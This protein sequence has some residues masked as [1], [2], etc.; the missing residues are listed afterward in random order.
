MTKCSPKKKNLHFYCNRKQ[1][2]IFNETFYSLSTQ[3]S[4]KSLITRSWFEARWTL[5]AFEVKLH[6]VKSPVWWNS[7][8]R[9]L[10][11]FNKMLLF[12]FLASGLKKLLCPGF[13][14]SVPACFLSLKCNLYKTDADWTYSERLGQF[15]KPAEKPRD[16][17]FICSPKPQSFQAC[18]HC[19]VL[20]WW[21]VS[22]SLK[23]F[24][25]KERKKMHF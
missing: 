25:K 3:A 19:S 1:W 4:L 21:N 16:V 20:T 6:S 10:S 11:K 7:D 17:V 13:L 8:R 2:K 23:S 9:S 12:Y 15:M 24:K 18:A 14:W 5:G 22:G